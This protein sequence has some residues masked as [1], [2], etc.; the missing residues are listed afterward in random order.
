MRL[1]DGYNFM[2]EEGV[3]FNRLYEMVK[4]KEWN[5]QVRKAEKDK[6]KKAYYLM[7]LET[8]QKIDGVSGLKKICSYVNRYIIRNP[9]FK[10]D[11]TRPL[12]KNN[13]NLLKEFQAQNAQ[14]VILNVVEHTNVKY[15]SYVTNEEIWVGIKVELL[16]YSF[17]NHGELKGLKNMEIKARS[18]HMEKLAEKIKEAS[19]KLVSEEKE[20]YRMVQN[21]GPENYK[22]DGQATK[23]RES[24]N[25]TLQLIWGKMELYGE[26]GRTSF[27]KAYNKH[28]DRGKQ[29][30][31]KNLL[32]SAQAFRQE[33]VGEKAKEVIR[34][35]VR[36]GR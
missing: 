10:K 30:G 2:K 26:K 34:P 13:A 18:F 22:A 21:L 17:K 15:N 27:L 4:T 33:Q 6:L 25:K 3:F 8:M 24:C 9:V 5:P 19:E 29:S 12:R 20:L 32:L 7:T 23:F 31:L 14:E 28:G 35:D 11:P 1:K 16:R 36:E